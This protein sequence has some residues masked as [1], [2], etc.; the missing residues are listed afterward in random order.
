MNLRC[1]GWSMVLAGVAVPGCGRGSSSSPPVPVVD[2]TP[3]TPTAA[4]LADAPEIPAA[5]PGG[6]DDGGYTIVQTMNE[7]HDSR[8]YRG[9]LS[10]DPPPALIALAQTLYADLPRRTPPRGD[11]DDWNT[12]ATAL[13]TAVDDLAAAR[14][15]AARPDAARPDAAAAY[16]RAVNCNSCHTRHR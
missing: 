15:A 8:L 13:V 10:P 11:P 5:P 3:I 4:R 7:L 2:E 1:I 6:A 16:R 12:R 9:L 14:L